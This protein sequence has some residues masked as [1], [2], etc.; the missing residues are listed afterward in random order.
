MQTLNNGGAKS[1]KGTADVC[2]VQNKA[3]ITPYR[4]ILPMTQTES[5]QND[6]SRPGVA[7]VLSTLMI[8]QSMSHTNE[9]VTVPN[10]VGNGA[11]RFIS[12]KS[13][14]NKILHHIS[15][16]VLQTLRGNTSINSGNI[17]VISASPIGI[18]GSPADKGFKSPASIPKEIITKRMKITTV[19]KRVPLINTVGN[20]SKLTPLTAPPPASSESPASSKSEAIT[21]PMS[22]LEARLT[23][24]STSLPVS[25]AN[26]PAKAG[27]DKEIASSDVL[28]SDTS[29]DDPASNVAEPL[30]TL[31]GDGEL[32]NGEPVGLKSSEAVRIPAL[33]LSYE[34]VVTRLVAV[35]A[36]TVTMVD[37]STQV[38][39]P[40]EQGVGIKKTLLQ[41]PHAEPMEISG[42]DAVCFPLPFMSHFV[43]FCFPNFDDWY[44]RWVNLGFC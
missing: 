14:E 41:S 28:S 20:Q 35:E 3:K 38:T 34:K 25:A 27:R 9:R 11:Y 24:T 6:Q 19:A 21:K 40:G 43:V 10:G 1:S 31:K 39:Q 8:P 32:K 7:K 18:N 29:C 2:V 16:S 13:P 44:V 5:A 42:S 37:V 15:N 36:R 23:S 30:R 4:K 17:R 26:I 33:N 22:I 12:T